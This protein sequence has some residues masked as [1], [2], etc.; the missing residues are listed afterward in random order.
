VLLKLFNFTFKTGILEKLIKRGSFDI[1]RVSF[2]AD[3][4]MSDAN[5]HLT[6]AHCKVITK[7]NALRLRDVQLDAIFEIIFPKSYCMLLFIDQN[8][9]HYLTF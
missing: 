8:I 6:H 4:F 7:I 1:P 3:G 9:L 5:L 2:L